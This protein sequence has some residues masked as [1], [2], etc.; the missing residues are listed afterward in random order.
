MKMENEITATMEGI[1]QEIRVSA[2]QNVAPGEIVAV[3]A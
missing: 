1:V 3:I 2:G